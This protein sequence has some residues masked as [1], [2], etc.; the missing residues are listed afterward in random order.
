MYE[1][2]SDNRIVL[3]VF[4][5]ALRQ[6]QSAESGPSKYSHAIRLLERG[7][8]TPELNDDK[9]RQML[10]ELRQTFSSLR[11]RSQDLLIFLD[12]FHVVDRDIQPKL[13]GFIYSVARGNNIFL[14]LSAIESLTR[15]W[16]ATGHTGLQ[17]PHDAQT[18]KLDYNL[19]MPDKATK[20]IEGILDAHAVYSGL[21]SVRFLCTSADV[22]PRLIWVS[23]GVP[24]DAISMLAQAMTRGTT[25]NRSRVSVT[26]VNLA[27]SEMVVF[28]R[29]GTLKSTFQPKKMKMQFLQCWSG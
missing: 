23:A 26:D 12:D 17:V 2:R 29:C 7:K 22:L 25:S 4:S 14:K 20:H 16:D 3:D 27:A 28:K 24:R 10:P 6:L 9:I 19:T 11:E 8:E 18:I 5:D 1:K 15:S 21:P 13:L